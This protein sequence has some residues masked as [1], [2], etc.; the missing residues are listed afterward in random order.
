MWV[1]LH[2]TFFSI[3][4]LPCLRAQQLRGGAAPSRPVPLTSLGQPRRPALGAECS[5]P[6][7]QGPVQVSP[8]ARLKV[9]PLSWE[10]GPGHKQKQRKRS[11]HC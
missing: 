11:S 3:P 10:H 6:L 9:T 5:L 4:C 1:H 2:L 8:T 7:A